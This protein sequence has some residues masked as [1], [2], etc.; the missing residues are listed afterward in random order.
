MISIDAG[1]EVVA[2]ICLFFLCLGLAFT[3]VMALVLVIQARAHAYERKLQMEV[4]RINLIEV[5]Q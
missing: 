2:V 1:N 4:R 3:V 5:V